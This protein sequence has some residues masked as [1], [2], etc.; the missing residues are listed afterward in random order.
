MISAVFDHASSFGPIRDQGVR[1]SCMAFAASDA[2][3]RQI[4]PATVLSAEY[5]FLCG[6]HR[7]LPTQHHDGIFPWAMYAGIENDGQPLENAVPYPANDPLP[8]DLPALPRLESTTPLYKRA[9]TQIGVTDIWPCLKAGNT[10]IVVLEIT[11][12][13]RSI[14]TTGN[15]LEL[16]ANDVE[17]GCHAVIVVGFGSDAAKKGYFKIRNS[18]GP[19][20]GI[21]GHGWL[22]ISYLTS[23]FK[24]AAY[25]A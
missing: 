2:H 11:E 16:L 17:V 14:N 3:A 1:P 8:R 24:E 15:V 6:A 10:P 7:Q 21:A 18:W 25:Y 9:A 20:W 4:S 5:A 22:S 23:K 12:G 13:F 19:G